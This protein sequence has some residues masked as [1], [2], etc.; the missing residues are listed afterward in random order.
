MYKGKK[1][2]NVMKAL[3]HHKQA[4]LLIITIITLTLVVKFALDAQD[5]FESPESG[6]TYVAPVADI[7]V[8][9]TSYEQAEQPEQEEQA[10][11]KILQQ[12]QQEAQ[13][14]FEQ[15][16]TSRLQ[17]MQAAEQTKQQAFAAVEEAKRHHPKLV[18]QHLI[19]IMKYMENMVTEFVIPNRANVNIHLVNDDPDKAIQ[20]ANDIQN[21]ALPAL[22]DALAELEKLRD[23]QTLSLIY[24]KALQD[25]QDYIQ[26]TQNAL[27]ESNAVINQATQ[28][29]QAPQAEATGED[30]PQAEG[31]ITQP[32]AEQ[33]NNVQSI[34]ESE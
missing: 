30:L 34:H 12:E 17:D 21:K 6:M 9:N 10:E 3:A 27:A 33:D 26:K 25:A 14:D 18:R 16:A 32:S 29:K 24:P 8:V 31:Y 28:P 7:P 23:E 11:Q 15:Q 13:A 4:T 5:T 2:R 1:K 20:S 22:Q 19:D